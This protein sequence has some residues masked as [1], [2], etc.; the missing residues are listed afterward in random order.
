MIH[1]TAQEFRSICKAS[2]LTYSQLATK[3]RISNADTVRAW[4]SGRNAVTG[5]VSVL[6]EQFHLGMWQFDERCAQAVELAVRYGGIDGDHHK[7]WVI[8]QMVRVLT[9][10]N[11]DKV[12]RD[13]CD[14]E[15]G[16]DTYEWEIGIA[17]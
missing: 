16:P 8:D 1:M 13:A 10:E 3:L 17:P 4:A 15:D 12:V 9:G 14:G 5:P 7:A 11:Y 2:G 6:M